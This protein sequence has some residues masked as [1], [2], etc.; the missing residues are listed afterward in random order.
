MGNNICCKDD[1]NGDFTKV[2]RNNKDDKQWFVLTKNS[3]MLIEEP[4]V[5]GSR[6]TYKNIM[7]AGSLYT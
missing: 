1:S 4:A 3:F 2:R 7:E 6:K 5:V